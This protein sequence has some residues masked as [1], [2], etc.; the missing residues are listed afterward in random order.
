MAPSENETRIE[1]F[2]KIWRWCARF[3][4]VSVLWALTS[5][6]VITIAPSTVAACR[7]WQ[8][9]N[10][11]PWRAYLKGFRASSAS[12]WIEI[13]WLLGV[14]ATILVI[15]SL[16]FVSI[17]GSDLAAALFVLTEVTATLWAVRAWG[18]MARG[19]TLAEAL[20][21]SLLG[22]VRRP[23]QL[24]GGSLAVTA[25]VVI[26]VTIPVAIPLVVGGSLALLGSM[27]GSV[28]QGSRIPIDTRRAS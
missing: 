18:D 28:G 5:W 15:N 11:L 4:A 19:R 14:A 24:L 23:F 1:Q 8:T 22:L 6:P 26:A 27:R 10:D 17:R 25:L 13:P 21:W 9:G 3:G 12:L 16:R 2:L 7:A 20:T